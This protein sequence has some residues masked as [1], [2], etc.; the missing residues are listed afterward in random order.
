MD[1]IFPSDNDLGI[2][3][4]DVALQPSALEAPLWCWGREARSKCRGGTACFYADDY[5]FTAI[6]ENPDA[7]IQSG[8][9]SVVEVNYSVVEA[10]P[11]AVAV[12]ATYRKRWLARYWQTL[13]LRIWVDLCA[14]HADINLLGVPSGW[15]A[16]ATRGWDS[17]IED[18]DDELDLART[19]H[20]SPMLLVWAGGA[21][22]AQWCREHGAIHVPDPTNAK[23]R[24]GQG[25]RRRL[26]EAALSLFGEQP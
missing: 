24:P 1:L 5:R 15:R 13:G 4:L 7:I 25:T 19:F 21:L 20:D 17:R 16:F 9:S 6:W 18:L 2:P 11:R 3:T 8:V 22:V 12:W 10:S 26:R 14:G 23:W